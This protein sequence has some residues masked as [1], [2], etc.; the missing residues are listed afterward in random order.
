MKLKI[1]KKNHNFVP[2]IFHKDEVL[3]KF[4]GPETHLKPV[5]YR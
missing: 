3:K 5:G 4:Y 2:S 1:I